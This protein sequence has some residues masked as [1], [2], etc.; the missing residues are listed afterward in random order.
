MGTSLKLVKPPR[1]K[2]KKA[3]TDGW[4]ECLG[5][6]EDNGGMKSFVCVAILNDGAILNYFSGDADYLKTIGALEQ[7]KLDYWNK[8]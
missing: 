2:S 7:L 1:L 4:R 5:K 8:T 3:A 6:I